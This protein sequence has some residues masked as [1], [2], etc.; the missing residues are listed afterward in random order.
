VFS[1]SSILVAFSAGLL[2]LKLSKL[3][4]NPPF[5]AHLSTSSSKSWRQEF[6][7]WSTR[8]GSVFGVRS[9]MVS[10][11]DFLCSLFT[12]IQVGWRTKLRTLVWQNFIIYMTTFCKTT[13]YPSPL[14]SDWHILSFNSLPQSSTILDFSALYSYSRSLS[15]EKCFPFRRY[16][17]ASLIPLLIYCCFSFI[18][19]CQDQQSQPCQ[20]LLLLEN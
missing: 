5:I 12:S 6:A 8:S 17:L 7:Y 14:L 9:G 10:F 15:G 19:G 18:Y 4:L 13:A 16:S 3:H 2:L 20:C 11:I 1:Y